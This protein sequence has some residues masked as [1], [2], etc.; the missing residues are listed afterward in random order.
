MNLYK[1]EDYA[2][3]IDAVVEN[4][5]EQPLKRFTEDLDRIKI[6]QSQV[7]EREKELAR[8]GIEELAKAVSKEEVKVKHG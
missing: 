6:V 8:L 3:T 2:L 5:W 1:T 7:V 4:Y